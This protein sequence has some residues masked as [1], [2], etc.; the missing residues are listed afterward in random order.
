[1]SASPNCTLTSVAEEKPA[2]CSE[3]RQSDDV[4][5]AGSDGRGYVI[6]VDAHSPGAD[7]HGHHHEAWS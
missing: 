3:Q 1:M 7:D 5:Q 2:D 6:W 4:S